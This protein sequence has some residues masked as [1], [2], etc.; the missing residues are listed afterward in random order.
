MPERLRGRYLHLHRQSEPYTH[1]RFPVPQEREH[2]CGV[3]E[4]LEGG[5]NI[6]KP[7]FECLYELWLN[8]HHKASECYDMRSG[9][10]NSVENSALKIGEGCESFAS[11]HGRGNLGLMG[12]RQSSGICLICNDVPN[13]IP[14]LLLNQGLKV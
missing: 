4:I 7:S 12:D 10:L 11:D 3:L 5:V 13:P 9:V 1:V 6:N 2:V 8:E 14:T